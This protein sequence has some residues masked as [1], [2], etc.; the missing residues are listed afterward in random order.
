MS[1][2]KEPQ[3]WAEY[4]SA[5]A[6]KL[7]QEQRELYIAQSAMTHNGKV[8]EFHAPSLRD[9]AARMAADLDNVA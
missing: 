9:I 2:S 3:A 6:H 8:P 5:A 1:T 4:E 7:L